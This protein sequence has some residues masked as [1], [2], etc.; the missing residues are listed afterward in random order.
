MDNEEKKL[1]YFEARE[2]MREIFH[3]FW[4]AIV[5]RFFPEVKDDDELADY[6][7]NEML[8]ELKEEKVAAGKEWDETKKD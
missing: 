3:E 5:P 6:L 7:L 1:R 8:E 2:R 4:E